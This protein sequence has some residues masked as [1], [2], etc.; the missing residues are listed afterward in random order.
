MPDAARSIGEPRLDGNLIIHGDN[1]HA[2]KS[3]LPMVAGKVDCVFID[4]PYN[5]GN[6]G[7][8]YNDNV[9]SPMMQQWLSENPVGI[10]DGLRHDK[11]CAMMWPRLRLLHDLLGEAGSLWVTLDDNEIHRARAMLDAVFGEQ[12]F[13]ATCIWHKNFSPKPSAKFFSE[14]HDYLLIYAKRKDEWRPNLL[15]RTQ[16]MDARFTN[17][18]NDPRGP[19]TSGDLSARNYYGEG[20]YPI[21]CPSGRVVEAPPKGMYWRVSKT[22]FEELDCDGRI[23]WGENKNNQPRLKRFLSEVKTGR[24]PQ[25][26]WE[27][28]EVGHTQDAKKELLSILDFASSDDVFVTPKPVAL[29][30]RILE[31]ATTEYSIVLDSFAGSGTTAHAVLA[32]NQ[33][34]GGDRKFIL[35]ECEDYADKLTAE[36]LRRVINGYAFQGTRRE[37][38]LQQSLTFSD[39]KKADKL[40]DQIAGIENLEGHRFDRIEKKVRAGE[41]QVEGVQ[42]VTERVAGLGGC[43]TYCTLG[44]TVD[45]DRLLTGDALPGFTQLGALLFHM[46][47][48]EAIDPA[49]V[50]EHDGHGYLGESSAFHVWLIYKPELDFLKSRESALTLAKAKALSESK[51]G[52]KHLVFA[53]AKFVSQKML[54]EACLP[55]EF[56]P[57]PWALYRV[58]RKGQG[59][60]YA[61]HPL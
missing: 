35:V 19:W 40:L 13:V 56:A 36:R 39:L 43:F 14:D 2:L 55:V 54:D 49:K 10:E 44:K 11:W 33:R 47:T 20:T 57:L 18:D 42:A 31:L 21:T 4:P 23:W 1:L 30:T 16:D 61:S 38:L 22:K 25:T 15:E 52:K 53:P 9:N 58:E 27:Y 12:N 46:A 29:L 34:D 59:D 32:A 7:W 6:E 28:A 45:L 3:L 50:L 26:L 37:T 5:T 17:P 24:V 51:P 41:L 48:N 8:R 60:G